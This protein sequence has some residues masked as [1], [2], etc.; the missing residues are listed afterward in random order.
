MLLPSNVSRPEGVLNKVSGDLIPFAN[1]FGH[2]VR[3][4]VN[5]KGKVFGSD[6]ENGLNTPD[7][8][9]TFVNANDE[10][11]QR[12]WAE[13]GMFISCFC[14]MKGYLSTCL[15]WMIDQ[16]AY[17]LLD[18]HMQSID[19]KL[20]AVEITHLYLSYVLSRN[21][22]VYWKLVE[23]FLEILLEGCSDVSVTSRTVFRV[24]KEF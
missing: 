6:L 15:P 20:L 21:G 18:S 22:L 9:N 10:S 3:G 1:V 13:S 7:E 8:G 23:L 2:F 19:L 17:R 5:T 16:D 14:P 24:W 12:R 11:A 4:V